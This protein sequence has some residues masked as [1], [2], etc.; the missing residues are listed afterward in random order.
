DSQ[1]LLAT[2]HGFTVVRSPD[3]F[4]R[5]DA[6]TTERLLGLFAPEGRPALDPAR[7]RLADMTRV[8]LDIVSRDPDGFFLLIES[9]GTDEAAHANAPIDTLLAVLNDLDRAI[10]V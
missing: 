2:D 1:N 6:A 3:E 9:E 5:V 7:P 4:A 10:Q 8:A